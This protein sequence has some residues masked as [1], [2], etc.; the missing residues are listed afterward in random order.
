M[1]VD[2]SEVRLTEVEEVLAFAREQG[3]VVESSYLRHT[4]SLI[5]RVDDEIAAVA[6]CA[7]ITGLPHTKLYICSNSAID[8]ADV[9]LLTDKVMM[10]LHAEKLSKFEIRLFGNVEGKSFWPKSNWLIKLDDAESVS[11]DDN[12]NEFVIEQVA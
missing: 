1:P 2:M 4:L 9:Q 6:V 3:C 8:D 12:E 7:G 11:V 10:K 5:A